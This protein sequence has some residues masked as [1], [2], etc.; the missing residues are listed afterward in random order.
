M[1]K[2][3]LVYSIQKLEEPIPAPIRS[4]NLNFN[5]VYRKDSATI[6]L[7]KTY[8][9]SEEGKKSSAEAEKHFAARE[10]DKAVE[11]YKK[12]L[13]T[14]PEYYT[15]MT[16]IG[17]VYGIQG[18]KEQAKIWY[19]KA[20]ES[21][22]IDYMAHWFLADLYAETGKNDKALEEITIAQILNRNNP[23]IQMSLEQI[24]KANKL[25]TPEWTFH[26]QVL[27]DSTEDKTIK[28]QFGNNWMGYALGKAVWLYEPGYSESMGVKRG[29]VSTITEREC[30]VMLLST[31]EK[32]AYKKNPEFKVLKETLDNGEMDLYIVYEVMLPKYPAIA[33]SLSERTINLVKDYVIKYRG[34]KKD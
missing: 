30:L 15:V 18:K 25:K 24:Y 33:Y 5:N 1:E 31:L 27:I 28:I 32:K 22:Y 2:S 21:N 10:Y 6:L 17:Q 29:N 26:P 3:E 8:S 19:L 12:V 13:E 9:L 4:T 14:D 23:R 11:M 16:Y 20:I 34:G 7:T